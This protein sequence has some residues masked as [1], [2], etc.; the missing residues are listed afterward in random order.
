M[1]KIFRK[2]KKHLHNKGSGLILVIVA[3]AFVGIL[4]G[5]LLTAVSY[6]YRQKL[7]D[8]N[9]K[10]NFNYLDQ[11]MDEVYERIGSLT[12]NDLM[13]AYQ[14]TREDIVYFDP[15]TKAYENMTNE[16]ANNIFK[17]YFIL[18]VAQDPNFTTAKIKEVI[19][20][21]ITVSN[22]E[23]DDT[24]VE[25]KYLVSQGGLSREVDTYN[26]STDTLKKIIIK[27]VKLVRT[28]SY[29]RSSARGSFQQSI[30][31]DI[32]IAKPKFEINFENDSVDINTLFGYCIVADQGIDFDR[33][34]GQVLTLNGNI[35]AANDFY[36]KDYNEAFEDKNTPA[37]HTYNEALNETVSSG[38]T[39]SDANFIN[40]VDN[41]TLTNRGNIGR[42]DHSSYLASALSW[43]FD[44]VRDDSKYSGLYIDGGKINVLAD[45]VIVP[46]SIAVMNGGSLSVYGI[47][48]GDVENTNV[49]AD[50]IV[51]GGY[52]LDL[53]DTTSGVDLRAGS[54]ANFNANLYVRDD[55]T[56]ESEWSKI[57]LSG[58][59]YGFSNSN[60]ADTRSFIKYVDKD[61]NGANA[62]QKY[63]TDTHEVE[64]RGHYNSSAIIV[65]GQNSTLDLSETDTI[66]VAGRSYIELSNSKRGSQTST[67]DSSKT[68]D[69]NGDINYKSNVYQYDSEID[70]YRT[71]ESISVKS[72]QL[73]YYPNK[74]SGEIMEELDNNNQPTGRVY[75]QLNASVNGSGSSLYSMPLIIKYFG[76]NGKIPLS[77]QTVQVTNLQNATNEKTY[78]Y[79]DFEQVVANRSYDTANSDFSGIV[80]DAAHRAS[81]ADILKQQFIQ[82]YFDYFN[83][84]VDADTEKKFDWM[85][86]EDGYDDISNASKTALLTATFR[87]KYP[88]VDTSILDNDRALI[89]LRSVELQNVTN[90]GDFAAGQIAVPEV[91]NNNTLAYTSG[92]V[93][94]SG[95]EILNTITSADDVVFSVTTD[96][97]SVI[98]STLLDSTSTT[99]T[100]G[101]A[102]NFSDDYLKHYQY[103]RWALKDLPAGDERE[104]VDR[105]ITNYGDSNITPLNY[106]LNY[107]KVHNVSAHIG[108][109]HEGLGESNTLKLGDGTEYCVWFGDSEIEVT[110][111]AGTDEVTGIVVTTGNV[112]FN[113]VKTFNGLIVCGG[114]V[115]IGKDNTEITNINSTM[116]CRNVMNACLAEASKYDP[117]EAP[118]TQYN[119]Y[120][121][122]KFLEVFQAYEDLAEKALNGEYNTD[123]T[124]V[125]I[126]SVTYSDVMSY[127]NWMRNVD[128]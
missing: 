87:T 70:D 76:S 80:G 122:I 65:N 49:W 90:Y 106:Y 36:N 105:L 33:V 18:E 64:N 111:P 109:V 8:Y 96:N 35:Y 26:A 98:T 59:Y 66:Y 52:T 19:K 121:A 21:S 60:T 120:N 44:G 41:T 67:K 75:Y 102:L 7:Y 73:A 61:L 68:S 25:V 24:N 43:D 17:K 125:D 47:S 101:A 127:N 116:V 57:K 42:R 51:L 108:P 9:A 55:T 107:D 32:E 84:C 56:I 126:L 72:S 3:L 99:A 110:P 16:D 91:D 14:K 31:T 46:G 92:A 37:G 39:Y 77:K 86:Y 97:D 54:V 10:S 6:V 2:F 58:G 45:T 124:N 38:K 62:Y 30:S 27:N 128:D 112:Y 53:P 82:D 50:E 123:D 5:A 69:A 48:T 83:F 104:L 28:E 34:D 113:G 63:N 93:T 71:G 20:K 1:K 94:S 89:D 81:D 23:L 115:F 15:N 22:I 29:G 4:V 78:Y 11:A 117:N 40:A 114:K 88:D 79:I 103:Y 74:A 95:D 100:S 118:S 13:E 12:M 119:A 85:G